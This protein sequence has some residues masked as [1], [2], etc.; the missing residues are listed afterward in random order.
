MVPFAFVRSDWAWIGLGNL[1][2][3][4]FMSLHLSNA[5]SV[6]KLQLLDVGVSKDW[7][8]LQKLSLTP[9]YWKCQTFWSIS[10]AELREY[11]PLEILNFF[12]MN[13]NN[14][15]Q[16]TLLAYEH[17]FRQFWD[18]SNW[19]IIKN[20]RCLVSRTSSTGPD[21]RKSWLKILKSE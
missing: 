21:L 4:G 5:T 17:T 3:H 18:R 16:Q 20:I 15:R 9:F 6:Y 12:V 7:N 13:F 10:V 1:S 2:N 11:W 8:N 14:F 19:K